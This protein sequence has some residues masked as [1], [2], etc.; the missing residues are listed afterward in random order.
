MEAGEIEDQ[1][2]SVREFQRA[3]PPER[4]TP[5]QSIPLAAEKMEMSR[6]QQ[7]VWIVG[8]LLALGLA[9]LYFAT[10]LPAGARDAE[11]QTLL[12]MDRECVVANAASSLR[13]YELP[14][15]QTNDP[16]APVSIADPAADAEAAVDAAAR[17]A[18]EAVRAI[19]PEW[20]KEVD[21]R[22]AEFDREARG[23]SELEA[24][25][26]HAVELNEMIC[27]ETGQNCEFAKMAR[28]QHIER[29]GPF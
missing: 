6:G 16:L 22:L 19:D 1:N 2:E 13:G 4:A 20:Q 24:G 21:R 9:A 18:D 26:R 3:H 28:R 10:R 17:A 25:S 8:T 7:T 15:R 29:Y 27:R 5:T 12:G 23:E 14:D 11:C